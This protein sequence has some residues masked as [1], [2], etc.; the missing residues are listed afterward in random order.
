MEKNLGDRLRE[1]NEQRMRESIA[2]QQAK[3]EQEIAK[4]RE[5]E[6]GIQLRLEMV[7]EKIA[8]WIEKNLPVK[9]IAFKHDQYFDVYQWDHYNISDPRHKYYRIFE[10]H[11]IDWCKANGLEFKFQFNHDGI[12]HESWYELVVFPR[13]MK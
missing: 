7:R 11:F 5:I 12:G 3:N 1:Q 10:L 2:I 8:S 4:V 9:P 13:K 6:R